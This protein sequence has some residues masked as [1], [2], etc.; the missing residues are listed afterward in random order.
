MQITTVPN[1]FSCL[2]ASVLKVRLIKAK[3]EPA[4]TPTRNFQN[5]KIVPNELFLSAA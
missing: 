4:E 1:K 5:D 2:A 3:L